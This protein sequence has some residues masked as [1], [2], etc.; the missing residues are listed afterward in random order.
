MP[1]SV[2]HKFSGN[3]RKDRD[4]WP[5]DAFKDLYSEITSR[6][7]SEE[8]VLLYSSE[9]QKAFR[10]IHWMWRKIEVYHARN[11]TI[12]I[13]RTTKEESSTTI[14]VEVKVAGEL[15]KKLQPELEELFGRYTLHPP[16]K[17]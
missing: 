9:V 2:K 6:L 7:E 12:V 15:E 14:E 5:N 10:E 4:P 8:G 16:Y 17:K 1:F 11:S 13:D 3:L